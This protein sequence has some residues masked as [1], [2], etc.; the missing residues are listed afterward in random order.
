MTFQQRVQD[1][2]LDHA[3][4]VDSCLTKALRTTPEKWR[5]RVLTLEPDALRAAFE[6]HVDNSSTWQQMKVQNS[7]RLYAQ[8]IGQA[9]GVDHVLLSSLNE[10]LEKAL[11]GS[12]VA[13]REFRA[14]VEDGTPIHDPQSTAFKHFR[15]K[16]L[17]VDTKSGKSI[18]QF[19]YA[20]DLTGSEASPLCERITTKFL[21]KFPL[22]NQ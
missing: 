14:L 9:L 20:A 15:Y 6:D 22:R 12:P 5:C 18:W 10:D 11:A 7:D 19:T 16:A 17:L 4:I 3:A 13:L 21:R 8:R 2:S 1:G